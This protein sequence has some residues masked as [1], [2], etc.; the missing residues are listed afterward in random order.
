MVFLDHVSMKENFNNCMQIPQF[1]G[2]H[3]ENKIDKQ[4]GDLFSTPEFSINSNVC[5]RDIPI[6]E[7]LNER[8]EIDFIVKR[9]EDI[10]ENF[11]MDFYRRQ[12][13]GSNL[14]IWN[15]IFLI[16]A[17]SSIKNWVFFSK[18]EEDQEYLSFV[19]ND[20]YSVN[21]HKDEKTF[22]TRCRPHNV[23]N[24]FPVCTRSVACSFAENG[25]MK[26]DKKGEEKG[27]LARDFCRQILKNTQR[28]LKK[29]K[30]DIKQNVLYKIIVT[31][32]DLFVVKGDKNVPTKALIME[33]D[34][35]L[36]FDGK[37]VSLHPDD[38]Q[39]LYKKKQK[40]KD[41]YVDS[42]SKIHVL[43][44]NDS[45]LPSLIKRLVPFELKTKT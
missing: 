25:D 29:H 34:E 37:K 3:F 10:D 12:V 43:I 26:I 11:V 39:E 4:L 42:F 2:E 30:K 24:V 35:H 16:E 13:R 15:P 41:D 14:N 7:G 27:D 9:F 38:C 33:L 23:P 21:N 17:K 40:Y 1:R 31:N 44:C 5:F 45:E 36:F 18:E 22:F 32:A 6:D 20:Q 28:F 8:F 19:L